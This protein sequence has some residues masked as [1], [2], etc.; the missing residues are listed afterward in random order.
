MTPSVLMMI[1]SIPFQTFEVIR[2]TMFQARDTTRA[3]LLKI[4]DIGLAIACTA[5]TT[6]LV[7][8]RHTLDVV[9]LIVR[10]AV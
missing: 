9:L 2:D 5:L 6:T 4:F 1:R 10:Q 3:M 8:A 7:T